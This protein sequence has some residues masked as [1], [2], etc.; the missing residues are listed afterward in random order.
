[1]P[2]P[3][4]L[5][6]VRI[7]AVVPGRKTVISDTILSV[8][9][10]ADFAAWSTSGRKVEATGAAAR[11]QSVCSS[12]ESQGGEGE[13]LHGAGTYGESGSRFGWKMLDCLWTLRSVN[14]AM[15][16][17]IWRHWT[18]ILCYACRDGQS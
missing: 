9:E 12:C 5:T 7:D 17:H 16:K 13:V 2:Y 14:A 4:R 1:M 11:D 18:H 3:G 6:A 15:P 8:A 10:L